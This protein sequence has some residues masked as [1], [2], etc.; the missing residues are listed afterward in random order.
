MNVV[1]VVVGMLFIVAMEIS[2]NIFLI[3]TKVGRFEYCIKHEMKQLY[4]ILSITASF[5]LFVLKPNA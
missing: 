5:K 2:V 1:V 4:A 3:Q